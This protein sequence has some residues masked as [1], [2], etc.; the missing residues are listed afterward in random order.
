MLACLLAVLS[1]LLLFFFHK[2]QVGEEKES[3]GRKDTRHDGI[4]IGRKWPLA[5]SREMASNTNSVDGNTGEIKDGSDDVD[6]E[7]KETLEELLN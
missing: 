4:D 6:E 3:Q 7:C 5:D 2:A 1:I